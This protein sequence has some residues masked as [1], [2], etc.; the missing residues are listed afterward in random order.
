MISQSPVVNWRGLHVAAFESYDFHFKFCNLKFKQSLPNLPCSTGPSVTTSV[1]GTTT[2]TKTSNT[3]S[4]S[5]TTTTFLSTSYGS[6]SNTPTRRS[7][8]P[9]TT[10]TSAIRSKCKRTCLQQAGSWSPSSIRTS[11]WRKV[12]LCTTRLSP[13][14]IS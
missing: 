9:G 1:G 8:S 10:S 5:W 13:T 4:P 3:S 2:L 6:T 11:K 7:I 12:T 14:V